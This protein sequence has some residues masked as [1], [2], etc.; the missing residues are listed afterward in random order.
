LLVAYCVLDA[1][2]WPRALALGALIGACALT[3]P[4]GLLLVLFVGGPVAWRAGG[5]LWRRLGRLVVIAL[6]VV[7]FVLPW[8]VRNTVVFGEPVLISTN[9]GA[10]WRGANCEATYAGPDIGA[11]R[12]DCL[13]PA[14]GA[15]EAERSRTWRREGLAYAAEHLDRLPLV[16][17]VRVLR[18]WNLY[19]PVRQASFMESQPRRVALAGGVA[20]WALAL[21]GAYGGVVLYRRRRTLIVLLGPILMVTAVAAI[22]QG[23]PRFRYAADVALVALAAVALESLL[24]TP[25]ARLGARAIGVA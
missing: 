9:E 2:S 15:N 20:G 24:R 22:G 5:G 10:L 11:W 12:F 21:L 8:T 17:V 1:P 3:R 19:Q 7:V 23:G 4:D 25:G 13:T 16:M 6:G 18:T 14:A